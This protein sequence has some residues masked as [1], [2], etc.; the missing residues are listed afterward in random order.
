MQ[1]RAFLITNDIIFYYVA[2]LDNCSKADELPT[3]PRFFVDAKMKA[4][5]S[6]SSLKIS[7]KI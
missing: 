7:T 3:F 6:A 5:K 1:S 2:T 4:S